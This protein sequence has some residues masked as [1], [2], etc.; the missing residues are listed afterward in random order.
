MVYHDGSGNGNAFTVNIAVRAGAVHEPPHLAGMSHVLEHLLFKSQGRRIRETV[1]AHGASINAAT[2]KDWTRYFVSCAPDQYDRFIDLL[3]DV[4]FVFKISRED[5]EKEKRIVLQEK[6]E[7]D[8]LVLD[9]LLNESFAGTPYEKSIIGNKKTVCAITLQDLEAYHRLRYLGGGCVVAATCPA[10]IL[11]AVAARLRRTFEDMGAPVP[12]ACYD[13]LRGRDDYLDGGRECMHYDTC[14]GEYMSLLSSRQRDTKRRCQSVAFSD[15][16]GEGASVGFN[17]AFRARP[18]DRRT[19]VITQ[20]VAEVLT[21]DL[22]STWYRKLREEQFHVYRLNM[23]TGETFA[24]AAVVS[25]CCVSDSDILTVFRAVSKMVTQTLRDGVLAD[26]KNK[27]HKSSSSDRLTALKRAFKTKQRLEFASDAAA[28]LERV[29]LDAFY[30]SACHYSGDNN[31]SSPFR[32][33][34]ELLDEIDGVTREEI[35]EI[36]REMFSHPLVIILGN[37]D[38]SKRPE[39]FEREAHAAVEG[40]M[41]AGMMATATMK[42]EEDKESKKQSKPN[43]KKQ[44]KL[45]DFAT[46]VVE[47]QGR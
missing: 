33:I 26:D 16:H 13:Y 7:T 6:N 8:D 21:G 3:Y 22:M 44:G 40:M 14:D 4:V 31:E 17:M 9:V 30:T 24:G 41:T 25:L 29:T 42:K 43:L 45:A 23:N 5:V 19:H 37:N 46:V 2:S 28:A 20:F 38:K 27:K 36:A 47:Q 15:P 32:T 35:D 12:D 18:Y 1:H 11:D 34:D 39:K 10:G